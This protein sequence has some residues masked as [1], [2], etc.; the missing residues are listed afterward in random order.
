MSRANAAVAVVAGVAALA[1][2]VVWSAGASLQR[3]VLAG[4]ALA[5]L[6][7][8]VFVVRRP[9]LAAGA[10]AAVAVTG[11]QDPLGKQGLP[12]FLP[13]LLVI[14]CVA[15]A[16]V[17]VNRSGALVGS[18][19]YFA[20]AAWLVA[21]TLSTLGS[22][23]VPLSLSVLIEYL[24]QAVLVVC[25][26]TLCSVRGVLPVVLRA[27]VAALAVVATLTIVRQ[28][29]GNSHDFGGLSLVSSATQIGGF[30]RHQGP[31]TDPNFW[32]RVLLLLLPLAVWAAATATRFR[33]LWWWCPVALSGALLL[34]GSRGG[35]VAF[36]AMAPLAAL[37]GGRRAR[38]FFGVCLVASL[39][40][41]AVPA[42]R[43]LVVDLLPLTE[44]TRGTGDPSL[45]G[46]LE[47]QRYGLQ[48]ALANPVDGV[49]PGN[50]ESAVEAYREHYGTSSSGP[51]RAAHNTYLQMAAEG[52]LLGL[53][54]S[55][56]LGGAVLFVG[57]RAHLVMRLRDGAGEAPDRPAGALV[58]GLFGWAVASV[59]LHLNQVA[60]LAVVMALLV[61]LDQQVRASL[62][63][64][65][66]REMAMA[67]PPRAR[68][69]RRALAIASV[70]LALEL[71]LVPAAAAAANAMTPTA[72][73]A[74]A[75]ITVTPRSVNATPYDLAVSTR[76]D[77]VATFAQLVALAP[78]EVARRAIVPAGVDLDVFPTPDTSI[79]AVEIGAPTPS[80]AREVLLERA[81]AAEAFLAS[82]GSFYRLERSGVQVHRDD[83][84]LPLL[85]ALLIFVQLLCLVAVV[86][87]RRVIPL[88]EHPQFR[89]S[90]Q[91][92]R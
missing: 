37:L 71:L 10:V 22:S 90:T 11:I 56:L 59:F 60:T 21:Q 53:A 81:T 57:L 25:V 35:I 65:Y 38:Q 6:P 23:G 36:F 46:R 61:A 1:V 15:A 34:T 41:L 88:H 51:A 44:A 16:R 75:T 63:E 58:S 49:G 84:R 87:V 78:Q 91:R 68:T 28:A 69:R 77:L 39:A 26:V 2:L 20:G 17:V 50:F 52:G 29:T 40:L 74:A 55:L 3:A 76:P 62:P 30:A 83:Q 73:R 47:A 86:V 42:V 32:A 18:P 85:V 89:R 14:S 43:S 72:W 45:V 13:L 9:V 54:A 79:I 12:G 8:A 5:M 4:L 64:I 27:V 7:S 48:L 31:L 70:V 67:T 80:L 24:L 92:S 19:V 33:A 82:T 66:E